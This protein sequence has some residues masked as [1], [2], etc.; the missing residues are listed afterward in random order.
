MAPFPT[1]AVV[2]P[3]GDDPAIPDTERIALLRARIEG[4]TYHVIADELA[5]ALLR[6]TGEGPQVA[7]PELL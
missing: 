7:E 2:E 6:R 5:T 1:P 4:G 3:R